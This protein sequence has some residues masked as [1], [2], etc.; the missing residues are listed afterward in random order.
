MACLVRN[1]LSGDLRNVQKSRLMQIY[2]Y[3]SMKKASEGRKLEFSKL[4]GM[5]HL[6]ALQYLA[7]TSSTVG[8]F[9]SKSCC[10]PYVAL[11]MHFLLIMV[12][13]A[14]PSNFTIYSS[15]LGFT[16]C[17][18]SCGCEIHRRPRLPAYPGPRKAACPYHCKRHTLGASHMVQRSLPPC[19]SLKRL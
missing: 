10:P 9:N 7:T 17:N 2:I 5:S 4:F 1:S 15:R 14:A 13:A 16:F 6:H 3:V 18:L 11:F 8:N 19:S 12:F